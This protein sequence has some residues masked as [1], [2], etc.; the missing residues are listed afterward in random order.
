MMFFDNDDEYVNNVMYDDSS[1]TN[2]LNRDDNRS[3]M[4]NM[5]NECLVYDQI[6]QTIIVSCIS[7]FSSYSYSVIKFGSSAF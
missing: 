2:D 4:L 1:I 6:L 7:L 5:L 3:D